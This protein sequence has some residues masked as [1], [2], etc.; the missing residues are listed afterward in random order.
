MEARRK[1]ALLLAVGGVV[2]V[3]VGIVGLVNGGEETSSAS[4]VT[5][6]TSGA[7]SPSRGATASPSVSP[8]PAASPSTSPSSSPSE[9]AETPEA[10]FRRFRAAVRAGK[11]AFLLARLHPFV[12]DRYAD[13]DCRTYLGG[14]HLPA[15]DVR[16]LSVGATERFRWKTDG[17]RRDVPMTTTVRIRYTEDGG[18]FVETDTHL[19][20]SSDGSL[21]FLTDCGTPKAGAR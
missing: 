5:S 10:F 14:L 1:L 3:V 2:A 17:L 16:V 18:T 9:Q 12:L 6:P 4:P 21:L 11:P 13:A 15:Y 8:T 20:R 7:P 19:V